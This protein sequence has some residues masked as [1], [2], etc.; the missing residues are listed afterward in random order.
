M[1]PAATADHDRS[2]MTSEISRRTLL[3]GLGAAA[4][5]IPL[6]GSLGACSKTEPGGGTSTASNVLE[7][8]REQ[9]FLRVAV[10]SEPPYTKL[11]ADGTVTGAEPDVLRAVC[12][13]L[14]ID[15]IEGVKV[16]YESMI[17]SLQAG[18]VDVIAAGLFM[19]QSRCAEVLYSEPVIVSTESFG[20]P[21]GNPQ[22][23]L[24]V[25]DVLDNKDLKIAVLP[26]GFEEGILNSAG[27]PKGQQVTVNDNVSGV[28]AVKT[29]RADAFFFPP[30]PSRSLS[31]PREVSRSRPWSRMRPRRGPAPHG[32]RMNKVPSMSTTRRWRSS[33]PPTNSTRS[34]TNGDSTRTRHE[35][36]PHKSSARL[37][38]ELPDVAES[39]PCRA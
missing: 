23:I 8:G 31:R 32:R 3:R 39:P 37:R 11:E 38:A 24:T 4:V 18:R 36:L 35:A 26:G 15:D 14:G 2:E 27:V 21:T 33:K 5:G 22:N 12:Q 7:R 6:V 20:V 1:T 17:P 19:K 34:W 28:E 29:D 13:K 30:F 9:G 10:F 25:Q 16:A